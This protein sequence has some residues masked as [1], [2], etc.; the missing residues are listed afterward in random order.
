MSATRKAPARRE[1][2]RSAAK[3]IAIAGVTVA[4]GERRTIDIP[5]S[6]LYTHAET[7]MPVRVVRGTRAGP[8][9]FVSAVIHGDELNG[10]EIIRRLL[11]LAILKRLRG[12]LIAIPIVNVYGCLDRS[13]YLPDGRDL[14]R[15]F[16]GSPKGS[17]AS[18]L[19]H[20]FM[21]EVVEGS[22]Y[23]IDLHTAGGHRANLP[24]VRTSPEVPETHAMAHAFGAPVMLDADLRDGSLRHAALER[25]IPILL[26][27]AGEALR[28]DE[29][30]IR[31]GVAGILGVMRHVGML[32]K[33]RKRK[34]IAPMRS[35]KSV[36]VRAPESGVFRHHVRLGAIVDKGDTIGVIANPMG[37][38]ETPIKAHR[39]GLV[40][41]TCR[42]PL[43][44]EGEA[45]F[46]IAI[47]DE[48][49][50]AEETLGVFQETHEP[51]EDEPLSD[52]DR[53]KAL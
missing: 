44:L 34:L 38:D 33:S 7:F 36:W 20:R 24:Q 52:A 31:A 18:R 2:H 50:A 15:S 9:M 13:R 35:T 5:L 40:I 25:G 45:L 12:T 22:D 43:V 51:G 6:P 37:H 10:M 14:N 47:L 28:Y 16:P 27:E 3:D 39:S 29:V 11:R 46:H 26:Y 21:A 32:P 19:A 30:S 1:R 48:L 41:G 49:E 23:G 53:P 4:P 8:R 42:L 17:M